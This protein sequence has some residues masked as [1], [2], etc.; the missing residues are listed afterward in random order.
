VET[1]VLLIS[2]PHTSWKRSA[3][4]LIAFT[5]IYYV[6]GKLGLRL[7]FLQPSATPVWPPT[8]I[9]LAAFLLLGSWIWPAIFMGAFLVN[10]TTAGSVGTSLGIAAGN[11]LEG[12]VGC[13]LL[14]RIA[15]GRDA[16]THV[17]GIFLFLGL[18][19]LAST[20]VSAT[21]G[22]TSLAIGGYVK[23]ERYG[24]V[25][26]TWWLGDATG[27][28]L[29]TPVLVLWAL[30]PHRPDR[31]LMMKTGL[32]FIA[33]ALVGLVIFAGWQ[34]LIPPAYPLAFLVLPM[35]VWIAFWLGPRETSTALLLL[36]AIAIWG[37]LHGHGPFISPN[38]NESLL[39]LQGFLGMIALT[40]LS[41]AAAVTEQRRAGLE[42]EQL[43]H[44]L[45]Q[46]MRERTHS[47]HTAV[48]ELREHD[49]LKNAL[50]SIVS[51]ELRTPLTSIKG[52]VENMLD[53]LSGSMTEKQHLCLYRV[54]ENAD[55]LTRRLNELLDLSTIEAG[56]QQ[57]HVQRLSV[58]A[59]IQ[60]VLDEFQPMLQ[61]KS[62]ELDVCNG[63]G[64]L[65]VLADEMKLQQVVGNLLQN[66]IKFTQSGGRITVGCRE[67]DGTRVEISVIDNGPGIPADELPDIFSKFYRG[68]SVATEVAGA[69]LGLAIA[70]GL[71][72][73][74]GGT[75]EVE[76][77]VGKGTTMSIA[78]PSGR[79]TSGLER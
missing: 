71:I 31:A 10:L 51:H 58:M 3:A 30:P 37:T 62:L 7:A 16:F 26:S 24:D 11:T 45:E 19:A 64:L 42:L 6:A 48:E 70:K 75:I 2:P 63:G 39:L 56:K 29:V 32:A 4:L 9:A 17:K 1:S 40:S 22:V 5:I 53:G 77:A 44:T 69:G 68:K 15:G 55:R 33:P 14:N 54:K 78:L 25:W 34:S 20:T 72:E 61:S 65:E 28:L 21:V 57:L 46:R 43:T 76:S 66:A 52:Y 35:F 27:A 60:E 18:A 23:W 79:A 73:L 8:G 49:C 47:L 41:L 38:P 50:L 74:H 13:F 59:L 67:V 12:L 36:A